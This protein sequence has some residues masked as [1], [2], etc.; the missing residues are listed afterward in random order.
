VQIDWIHV[1]IEITNRCNAK[2][3][4][5]PRD[6]TPHQGLMSPAVFEQALQRVIEFRD[7]ARERLGR[8]LRVSLCGLGEPLLNKHAA[9][10]VRAVRDAGFECSISSNGSLLDEEAARALLDAGLT[11]IDINVGDEGDDYEDV[12]KL[13][14]DRTHENVQRFAQMAEGRC[15]VAVVLVNHRRDVKHRENMKRFWRERGITEFQSFDIINRGGALF[16]DSMQYEALPQQARAVEMLEAQGVRPLC[17]FPFMF[18]FIG[19]DGEYY[20]CCSDWKKEVPLG[21]VIDAS[22]L[23]VVMTK[24][25]YTLS[26]EPVCKTCNFDPVN[27]LTEALHAQSDGE[28]TEVEVAGVVEDIFKDHHAAVEIVEGLGFSMPEPQPL[29]TTITEP[30]RRSI[31]VR[32]L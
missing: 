9:N 11:G 25:D 15:R 27:R 13:S 32:A 19:Y 31:P 6:Q 26:R 21:S 18:L 7:T 4:F 28:L 30:S 16:V 5:C 29:A 24:I 23:D 14:W 2:C 10:Y 8:D 3:Y 12:Y 17:N 1:D 22:F 20:L